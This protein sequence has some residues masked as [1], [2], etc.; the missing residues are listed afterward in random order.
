[1]TT[2]TGKLL[3]DHS[4][5]ADVVRHRYADPR[6]LPT[7]DFASAARAVAALEAFA[8]R[9]NAIDRKQLGRLM[10]S[11]GHSLVLSCEEARR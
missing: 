2:Q 8:A 1:M 5:P 9:L 11:T 10:V 7:H 4:Q 6:S 3:W